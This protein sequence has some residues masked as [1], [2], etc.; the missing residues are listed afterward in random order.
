[1]DVNFLPRQTSTAY[2]SA[3]TAC[4]RI[5][6]VDYPGEWLVDVP[7]VQQSFA[8]WSVGAMA[9]LT[10]EPW[11]CL[12]DE[13][14]A[15]LSAH[16]WKGDD[17]DDTAKSTAQVWQRLLFAARERG[18]RW[19]QPGRFVPPQGMVEENPIPGLDD[20]NLWFCPLPPDAIEGAARNSLASKMSE[21]FEFY[22]KGVK[23]FMG[24]TLSGA[25]RHAVL[26]DVLGALSND[27]V[28]FEEQAEVVH[29]VYRT[30]ALRRPNWFA[31][32]F[33]SE[34]SRF[35]R[36]LFLATQS[37]TVPESQ[38]GTLVTLLKS[39]RLGKTGRAA[40]DAAIDG[41][42]HVVAIRATKD[43]KCSVNGQEVPAVEG[44][45]ALDR[46]RKQV[47]V[48]D[49]P[50]RV[51]DSEYWAARNVLQIPKFVPPKVAADGRRGV[52]NVG[53]GTL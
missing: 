21:R 43:V 36:V 37:D 19:L 8:E 40:S 52:P 16:N 38:R 1:M 14:R 31:S 33:G 9:R 13:F 32:I 29:E 12:S 49:I 41:V 10:R 24:K 3:G 23:E 17:N 15:K 35:D 51:P 44:L 42:A 53:L 20:Q 25:S 7:L 50:D 39:M 46:V 27:R 34:T 2:A 4:L 48:L 18:L 11:S 26:V 28:A 45:C 47:A 5:I 22:Q 30:L 6:F